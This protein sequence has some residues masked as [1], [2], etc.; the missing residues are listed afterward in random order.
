MRKL[1]EEKMKLVIYL[2]EQQKEYNTLP[3]EIRESPQD[4]LL[5]SGV[6]QYLDYNLLYS[7]T[8]K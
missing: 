4:N 3:K 1:L 8:E 7:D 5:R 6:L 2:R